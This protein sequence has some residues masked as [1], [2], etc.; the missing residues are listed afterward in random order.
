M[1]T[2]KRTVICL[3]VILAIVLLT[4][5]GISV[6]ARKLEEK[7]LHDA[8]AIDCPTFDTQA[9]TAGT[10]LEDRDLAAMFE[11]RNDARTAIPPAFPGNSNVRF[12]RLEAG[13]YPGP[14]AVLLQPARGG[15][16]VFCKPEGFEIANSLSEAK[17]LIYVVQN[18]PYHSGSY[19]CR[20]QTFVFSLSGK[21]SVSVNSGSKVLGH[22]VQEGLAG[23]INSVP[24]A[25]TGSPNPLEQYVANYEKVMAFD[26]R[27]LIGSAVPAEDGSAIEYIIDQKNGEDLAGWRVIPCYDLTKEFWWHGEFEINGD[28]PFLFMTCEVTGETPIMGYYEKVGIAYISTLLIRIYDCE[29]GTYVEFPWHDDTSERPFVGSGHMGYLPPYIYY[30]VK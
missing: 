13:G 24:V 11:E 22:T 5:V 7:R 15:Q 2:K 4:A 30:R 6:G 23:S 17:T 28:P 29:A 20:Y 19:Y 12:S 18:G 14:F 3:A 8:A 25:E 21:Y 26:F 10:A 1:K 27:G 9:Y 16:P